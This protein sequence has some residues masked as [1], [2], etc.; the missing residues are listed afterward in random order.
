M[1]RS[2]KLVSFYFCR[3][4]P[5]A[6][7]LAKWEPDETRRPSSTLSTF[8]PA[9]LPKRGSG[10]LPQPAPALTAWSETLRIRSRRPKIFGFSFPTSSATTKGSLPQHLKRTTAGM[11]R[12]E[13]GKDP[14]NYGI[15]PFIHSY[16]TTFC[17]LFYSY[18][19]CLF[20]STKPSTLETI[21]T[22]QDEYVHIHTCASYT[23]MSIPLLIPNNL[24]LFICIPWCKR[25]L[26]MHRGQRCDPHAGTCC[27]LQYLN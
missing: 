16:I 9:T 8:P 19:F 2:S 21:R 6:E 18:N 10:P 20:L 17:Q 5:D 4:S 15:L 12:I 23:V 1:G 14:Y 13:P 24:A 26:E 3:S 11:G 25:I 27:P 22:R 7:L